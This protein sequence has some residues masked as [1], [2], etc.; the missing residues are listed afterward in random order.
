MLRISYWFSAA[1]AVCTQ[2]AHTAAT[3]AS[4]ETAALGGGRWNNSICLQTDLHGNGCSAE[5]QGHERV[6]AN[7]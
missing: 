7:S 5:H 2:R 4:S 1:G 6:K 3:R